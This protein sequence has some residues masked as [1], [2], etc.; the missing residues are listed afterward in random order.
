[1]LAD[2]MRTE[3]QGYQKRLTQALALSAKR[4]GAPIDLAPVV[5]KLVTWQR[6]SGGTFQEWAQLMNEAGGAWEVWYDWYTRVYDKPQDDLGGLTVEQ[7][8][9]RQAS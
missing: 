2:V 9:E 1:M 4:G 5:A 7:W 3:V 8:Y 6:A